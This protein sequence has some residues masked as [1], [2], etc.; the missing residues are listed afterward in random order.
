VFLVVS[1]DERPAGVGIRFVNALA[2]LDRLGS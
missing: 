1:P 2:F